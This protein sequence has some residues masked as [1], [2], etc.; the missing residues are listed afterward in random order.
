[1]QFGNVMLLFN[2]NSITEHGDVMVLFN[3]EI[4]YCFVMLQCNVAM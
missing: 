1:M 3:I 2:C 4:K